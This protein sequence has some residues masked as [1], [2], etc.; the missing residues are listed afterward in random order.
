VSAP[1]SVHFG[2]LLQVLRYLRGTSSRCLFYANDSPLQLLAYSDA[3]W[4]SDPGVIRQIGV[5]SLVIAFFLVLLLLHGSPRS[6]LLFPVLALRR[7]F[8]H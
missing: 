1:T 4:A 8:M 7:N 6:R 5:Q 3:T 2:H